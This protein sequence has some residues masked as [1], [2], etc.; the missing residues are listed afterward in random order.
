MVLVIKL[1]FCSLFSRPQNKK[2]LF[3]LRHASFRNIIERIFGVI[4]RRWR[5]LSLPPEYSM[6]IQA[7]IPA[8]LA[9]LHNFIREHDLNPEEDEVLQQGVQELDDNIIDQR[10]RYGPGTFI[11]SG[12][13]AGNFADA[14]RDAIASQMWEDYLQY[15]EEHQIP[16]HPDD[17]E[18]FNM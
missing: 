14:R 11:N 5:I 16:E 3:N 12:L 15:I 1:N 9:A 10:E 8:A 17:F 2:E 13:T 18:W 4:K 6:T 7:R